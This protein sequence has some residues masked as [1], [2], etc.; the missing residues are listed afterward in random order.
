MSLQIVKL[1]LWARFYIYGLQGIFTEVIYT[2]LWD[3]ITLGNVKLIGVSSTWAFFIYSLSHLF[4]EVVSP[5]LTHKYKIPLLLRAFVYLAWTYFWEFSTGYIL[6]LFGACPWN[7]EPWFNWHFMG[8]ITLEYAPLW[9]AGS[10]L[11][12]RIVIPVVNRLCLVN[13]VHLENG[14]LD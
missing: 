13:D 10:I 5:V 4:I 9:Y 8:L 14:K 1:P 3:F 2:A 7:Y 11:A 12:E 6:S